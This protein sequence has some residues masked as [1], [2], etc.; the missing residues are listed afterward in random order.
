M[1]QVVGVLDFG[2]QYTQVI[3]RRIRECSVYSRI[4]HFATPAAQLRADGVVGLILSGGPS[5]V[6]AETAPLPDRDI[7]KLGVPVLGI[8]YG[9]QLMG[10]LLGGKVERS[11]RREYGHGTLHI[12][13]KHTLFHGLPNELRVWNSHGDHLTKVPRG[14][15]AIAH[16]ENAPFAAIEDPK[17]RLVAIQFHP[18]VHHTDQGVRIV[19]NFLKRICGCTGDWSMA[20]FIAE[21]VR[22]IREQVGDGRVIL[23]LSGGVDS[24]VAAALIH[25]AIGRSAYL[26]VRRQRPAPPRRA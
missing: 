7:F 14:F 12:D 20:D 9:L 22:R 5:S 1:H 26:R 2:S 11:T 16:T 21:S 4:Y 15:R 17:R 8:C 24:S 19:D 25:R 13:S 18:E 3:A 6:Y 10:H 23:G